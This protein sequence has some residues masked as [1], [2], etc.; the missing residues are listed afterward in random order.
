M[1]CIRP[2]LV[3][4]R[5]KAGV[6]F[7]GPSRNRSP[8]PPT[9]L[10]VSI[11]SPRRRD[12]ANSEQIRPRFSACS[13]T[14]LPSSIPGAD[15]RQGRGR[16]SAGPAAK[17][18][19]VYPTS[20]SSDS[21]PAS[22]RGTANRPARGRQRAQAS[23]HPFSRHHEPPSHPAAAAESRRAAAQRARGHGDGGYVKASCHNKSSHACIKH[24]IQHSQQS[25]IFTELTVY[26]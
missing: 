14:G 10:N 13:P 23:S 3:T 26:Y 1:S 11:P 17:A 4:L 12:W 22:A 7:I 9:T 2:A 24:H 6:S 20:A 15:S 16:L 21:Q 19:P 18:R 5:G 8:R 25:Q